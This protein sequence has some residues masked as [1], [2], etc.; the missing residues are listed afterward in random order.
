VTLWRFSRKRVELSVRVPA[1]LS[2]N[3]GDVV[4]QWALKGKGL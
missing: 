4:R 2:S 1:I 3:D